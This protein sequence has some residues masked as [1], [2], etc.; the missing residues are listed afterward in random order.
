[1]ETWGIERGFWLVCC[2]GVDDCEVITTGSSNR[3]AIKSGISSKISNKRTGDSAKIGGE[4]IGVDNGRESNKGPKELPCSSTNCRFGSSECIGVLWLLSWV[5][6][7]EACDKGEPRGSRGGNWRSNGVAT[8]LPFEGW[9]KMRG[10]VVFV[11][12]NICVEDCEA[13]NGVWTSREGISAL[14]VATG[15]SKG[16]TW[17]LGAEVIIDG[18]TVNCS[19]LWIAKENGGCLVC[20]DRD[21]EVGER[22][23]E[24]GVDETLTGL[25][26]DWSPDDAGL[27]GLRLLLVLLPA[28]VFLAIFGDSDLD[29]FF[30]EPVFFADDDDDGNVVLISIEVPNNKRY[31]K[32]IVHQIWY[33]VS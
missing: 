5:V 4:E 32:T 20:D 15:L 1:M 13:L 33:A 23:R 14:V 24:D 10:L 16:L 3:L 21:G 7:L 9:G 26:T 25:S 12:C 28:A 19:G 22:G 18:C 2:C 11:N 6:V 27:D 8:W 29:L 17:E 30:L 31:Y